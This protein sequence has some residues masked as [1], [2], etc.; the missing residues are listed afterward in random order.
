MEEPETGQTRL[1]SARAR[2]EPMG[3]RGSPSWLEYKEESWILS[4]RGALDPEHAGCWQRFS[5]EKKHICF[6]FLE[7]RLSSEGFP[8]YMDVMTRLLRRQEGERESQK[9]NSPGKQ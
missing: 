9:V 6:L 8:L 1:K 3:M 5:A 7:E 2:R 4:R